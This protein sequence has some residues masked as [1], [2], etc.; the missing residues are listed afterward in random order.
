MR[1][2]IALAM[3]ALA[4][5]SLMTGCGVQA[6]GDGNTASIVSSSAP[7][8]SDTEAESSQQAG[9]VTMDSVDDNLDGMDRYF[10]AKEYIPGDVTKSQ[11]QAS[12]IG[13]VDGRRYAFSYENSN[14]QMELYE[15]DLENL[16]EDAQEAIDNANNSGTMVV[17]GITANGTATM[18]DN[19]KYLMLYYDPNTDETHQARAQE[20]L[21]EFKAFKS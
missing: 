11:T 16:N 19:G 14:I 21:E 1:K 15:F 6:V 7:E 8:G 5:A 20:I 18:S 9:E 10:T 12:F 3:A 17:M 13:A 2:L 4:T